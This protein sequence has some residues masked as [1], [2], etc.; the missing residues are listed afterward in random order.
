MRKIRHWTPRYIFNRIAL[1]I[2]E[3]NNPNQPWLTRQAIDIL[4]TYL[5][6]S[7]IGFEWGSGRSTTWIS[8]RVQH[9]TSIES[10]IEWYNRVEQKAKDLNVSNLDYH[11][12]TKSE[13]YVN[14][15]NN[16]EDESL[17]FVLVDGS[18][19]RDLCA[20]RA[21]NKMK[22]GGF[23]VLDN[24]NRFLPCY[25]YAP[26]SRTYQ[27]GPKSEKWKIFLD[28][29]NGWRFIWTSNG[30]SDTA[31]FFKPHVN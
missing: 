3:R 12:I 8:Q 23:I 14:I 17:D 15:I 24:A 1:G 26:A 29:I 20:L 7:D 10:N 28:Q 31:F 11:L 21:I 9:L 22:P 5:R 18:F 27:E 25:S 13:E 6:A 30:I 19:S 4:S 2:Y 16:L